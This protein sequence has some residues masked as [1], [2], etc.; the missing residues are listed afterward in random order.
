MENKKSFWSTISGGISSFL[1]FLAACCG[2][3]CAGSCGVVCVATIAAALGLSSV[4][5]FLN[6]WWDVLFPLMIALS[7]VSFTAAY[8]TIYKTTVGNISSGN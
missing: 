2:I 4:S 8:F 5:I 6:Q 7:S 3:G 1:P